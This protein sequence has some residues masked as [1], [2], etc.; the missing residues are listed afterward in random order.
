MLP[1]KERERDE[2]SDCTAGIF[3]ERLCA[4]GFVWNLKAD[5]GDGL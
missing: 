2:I 3:C 4:E 5:K 1:R